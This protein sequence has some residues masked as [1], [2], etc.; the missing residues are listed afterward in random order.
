AIQKESAE[1]LASYKEISEY[2]AYERGYSRSFPL[3]WPSEGRLTSHFGERVSPMHGGPQFHAGIDIA[4]E[5][6]TPVRATADG[7]VQCANWEGGY[8]RLVIIEHGFGY[9]TY[10]GHNSDLKVKA[11]QLVHRGQ[12]IAL[13]GST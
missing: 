3:G 10:Y 2:I 6:G 7:I 13:M 4:N 11:G 5:R 9:L 12:I 1:R 8:G